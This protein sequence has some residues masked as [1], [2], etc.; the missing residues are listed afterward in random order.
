MEIKIGYWDIPTAYFKAI[1]F[2][3]EL[4]INL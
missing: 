1:I 2:Y 3:N 4:A